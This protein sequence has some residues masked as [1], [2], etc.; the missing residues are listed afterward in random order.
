MFVSWPL[1]RYGVMVMIMLML[2]SHGKGDDCCRKEVMLCACIEL[3]QGAGGF[4]TGKYS[5]FLVQAVEEKRKRLREIEQEGRRGGDR[6]NEREKEGEGGR[7]RRGEG[8][9]RGGEWHTTQGWWLVFC[10][11]MGVWLD[12][13]W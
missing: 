11:L 13:E 5:R 6:A 4:H 3:T 10:C 7:R 2:M 8:G 1:A 9:G 12:G